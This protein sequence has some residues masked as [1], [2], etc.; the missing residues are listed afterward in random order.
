MKENKHRLQFDLLKGNKAP[1]TPEK[2]G[3]TRVKL[4]NNIRDIHGSDNNKRCVL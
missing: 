3:A 1:T 4:R 2:T